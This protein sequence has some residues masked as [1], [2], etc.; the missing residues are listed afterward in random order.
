L[1][2]ERG[3]SGQRYLLSGEN[4]TTNQ[5][6]EKAAAIGGVRAP[7]FAPPKFV[8]SAAVAIVELLSKIKGKPS[9][10]TR[11]VLQ[12]LGRYAWY[13]T[14]RARSELGWQSRPLQETLE[15]TIRWMRDQGS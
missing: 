9:P 4:V 11:D 1:A 8:L 5:L 3:R 2:S 12:L 13:D 6:F 7:R 10:V 15:D 14:T